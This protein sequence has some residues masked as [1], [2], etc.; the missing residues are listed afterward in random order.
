VGVPYGAGQAPGGWLDLPSGTFSR[1]PASVGV[2]SGNI[3]GWDAATGHWI[4]TEWPNVSPDGNTYLVV[5]GGTFRIVDARSGATVHETKTGNWFPN[6]VIGY[7]ASS[8]YLRA[9]GM[10]PPPGLWKLDLSSGALLKIS[11]A[12]GFWEVANDTTAW[13]IDTPATVR[14]M[15]LA[16]GVAKDV[17]TSPHKSV[18][19][20]GFVGERVLVFESGNPNGTYAASVVGPDGSAE[21]V[22]VPAAMQSKFFTGYFQDGPTVLIYGHGFGLA[23]YDVAHGLKVLTTTPELFVVFGRCTPA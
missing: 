15:D 13:G 23:A 16:T 7:T 19:V 17:Y 21:P 8:V 10:A 3:I 14:R 5:A 2:D 20:A 11:S 1:D 9:Q 18:D 22:A 4:P 6:H 12:P